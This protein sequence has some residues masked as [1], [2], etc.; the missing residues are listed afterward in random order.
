MRERESKIALGKI[1]ISLKDNNQG[2]TTLAHYPVFDF[3]IKYI[4]IQYYY[5]CNEFVCQ[6]I[7]VTNISMEEMIANNFT[8]A[9]I[10][11][12]FHH[13]IKQI[14]MIQNS[15]IS[16]ATIV[17]AICISV[18]KLFFIRIGQFV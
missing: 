14:N 10:Y 6:K 9:F 17:K 7:K 4:D 15:T 2:S 11:I 5:I 1:I 16:I 8:K 12:K 13:F 3:K 18:I